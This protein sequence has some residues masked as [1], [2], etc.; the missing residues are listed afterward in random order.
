MIVTPQPGADRFA[1]RHNVEMAISTLTHVSKERGVDSL[2]SCK[3]FLNNVDRHFR[4]CIGS[5]V[6]VFCILNYS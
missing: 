6:D 4:P 3:K 5:S 1:I 2:E